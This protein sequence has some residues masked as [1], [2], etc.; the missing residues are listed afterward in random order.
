[1]SA[2]IRV[3]LSRWLVTT[4]TGGVWPPKGLEVLD[5][6]HLPLYNTVILLLSGTTVTWAH[7]RFDPQ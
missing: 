4:F 3:K 6:L 1:M 2:F 5:P 7:Q